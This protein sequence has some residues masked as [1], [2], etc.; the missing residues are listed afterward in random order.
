MGTSKLAPRFF[1]T[2]L[3]RVQGR[4]AFPEKVIVCRGVPCPC[5]LRE[6]KCMGVEEGGLGLG[7]CVGARTSTWNRPELSV[8][9][10]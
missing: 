6:G 10:T 5:S 4:L 9:R 8:T 2:P 7:L 1:K 3:S